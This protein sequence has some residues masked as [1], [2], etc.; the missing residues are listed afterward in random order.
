MALV[1][2]YTYE[3]AKL[4]EMDFF[5]RLDLICASCDQALKVEHITFNGKKYHVEHFKCGEESC[6]YVF[7]AKDTCYLHEDRVYCVFHHYSSEYAKKCTGCQL[8]VLRKYVTLEKEAWHPLCY[9]I[10]ITWRV[11]TADLISMPLKLVDGG[12]V[13]NTGVLVDRSTFDSVFSAAMEELSRIHSVLMSFIKKVKGVLSDVLLS[14]TS[15]NFNKFMEI[16]KTAIYNLIVLIQAVELVEGSRKLM[17]LMS[18]NELTKGNSL[19]R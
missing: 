3:G 5:R 12:W 10:N 6:D 7:T 8:P 16:C 2:F 15:R 17:P 18:P 14:V 13:D 11:K 19:H 4:C 1:N 9:S